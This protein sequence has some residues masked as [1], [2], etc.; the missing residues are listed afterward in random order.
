MALQDQVHA[1]FLLEKQVRGMRERLDAAVSRTKAQAGKRGQL[2]QQ[3]DEL[4][5]QRKAA[6]A[7]ASGFEKDASDMEEKI[8]RLRGQ[9]N[10]VKNNKEYSALLVEVNTLKVDKGKVEEQALTHMAQVDEIAAKIADVDAKL[11]ERGKLETQ[12]QG[13]VDAAKAEVGDRLAQLTAE[14]DEAAK[15]LPDDVRKAFFKLSDEH[16]GEALAEV[17][18][19]SRR[20][21]EY[22]CGGCYMS[23][24][25]ERVNA[26]MSKPNLLTTCPNCGRM[27]YASS[28]LKT[29][30]GT[31]K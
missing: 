6:A 31:P 1:L 8:V 12:S 22:T 11:A 10:S 16:D 15:A 28:E 26:V 24:P 25:V 20:H 7:K 5:A 19:Q 27:L 18:E 17:E 4:E 9:M 13:E 29:A 2:Q 21:M 14:R 30:I 3:R 23:I